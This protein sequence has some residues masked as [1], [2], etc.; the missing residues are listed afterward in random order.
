MRIGNAASEQLQID[1]Y[2]E[3]MAALHHARLGSL[4]NPSE[5]WDFQRALAAH[6]EEIWMSRTRASGRCAAGASISRFPR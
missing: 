6:V 5:G 1:V 3:V 4:R 2:G